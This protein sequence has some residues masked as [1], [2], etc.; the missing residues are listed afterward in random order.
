MGF[1]YS[2]EL[3][4]KFRKE[5]CLW[6]GAGVPVD[7]LGFKRGKEGQSRTACLTALTSS[8][9]LPVEAADIL[10]FHTHAYTELEEGEWGDSAGRSVIV[11]VTCGYLAPSSDL[12]EDL[13]S[14]YL[15]LP[16]LQQFLLGPTLTQNG[17]ELWEVYFQLSY[18]DAYEST[19]AM[20][21]LHEKMLFYYQLELCSQTPIWT[22]TLVNW[23]GLFVNVKILL[24]PLAQNIDKSRAKGLLHRL[25]I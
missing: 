23:E 20:S 8:M 19:P 14:L 11:C 13:L 15:C 17:W 21:T 10:H 7:P 5:C 16:N 18:T 9:W 6:S 12:R 25:F 1:L 22:Q 24:L 3:G 2:W 4:N